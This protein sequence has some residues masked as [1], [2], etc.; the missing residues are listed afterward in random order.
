MRAISGDVEAV[1][2]HHV[3]RVSLRQSCVQHI[4]CCAAV[5]RARRNHLPLT[6][7]RF[8][9]LTSGMN[10]AVSASRGCTTTANPK[11]LGRAVVISFQFAPRSVDFQMPQ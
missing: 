7:T 5:T 1:P 9:S 2:I 3:V 10:H 11:L 4:E 6:G 8:W